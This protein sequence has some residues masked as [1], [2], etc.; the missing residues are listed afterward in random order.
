MSCATKQN[1]TDPN[2]NWENRT[3][4]S[5][6]YLK[7]WEYNRSD[8]HYQNLLSYIPLYSQADDHEVADD[9]SGKSE[10]YKIP[11]K[12]RKGFPNLIKEGLGVFFNFSPIDRNPEEPLRIYRSFQWGKDLEIFL[13]DAHQYR[14]PGYL[15][16]TLENNKTLLGNKQMDWLKK[17]LQNSKATWKAIITDVPVTIPNCFNSQEDG[18][19]NWATDGIVNQTFTRERAEFFKFLDDNYINNIISIVTDTHYPANVL[20]KEDANGDGDI[21]TLYEL[22][23]GTFGPDI[24]DP[25]INAKY[26]YNESGFFNFGHYTVQRDDNGTSHF[27]SEIRTSDGLMRPSSHLDLIAANEERK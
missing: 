8:K 25:T 20:V 5:D 23:S 11:S 9:Y 13:L 3:Q 1:I 17:G 24:L 6:M 7:H 26:L 22:V 16:E 19:D 21:I 4:L 14:S 18:C 10:F 27:I 2:V 15:P 12:D